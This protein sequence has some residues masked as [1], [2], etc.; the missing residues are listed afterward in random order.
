LK[1]IHL[2]VIFIEINSSLLIKWLVKTIYCGVVYIVG[3]NLLVGSFIYSSWFIL[4]CINVTPRNRLPEEAAP[5]RNA[6]IEK[7]VRRLKQAEGVARRLLQ[8]KEGCV[9]HDKL[10][11]VNSRRRR[12]SSE[13][14]SRLASVRWED[15]EQASIHW[16]ADT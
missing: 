3:S 8:A 13:G 7:V 16:C 15:E 5:G 6:R 2:Y 10:I 1:S 9:S 14:L 12:S 11:A 4:A